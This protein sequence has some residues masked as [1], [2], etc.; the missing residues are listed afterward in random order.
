MS[1]TVRQLLTPASLHARMNASYRM[2]T[3]GTIPLG[4]LLGGLLVERLGAAA[5]LW[6]V[7]FLF[8]AAVLPLAHRSVRALGRT[9]ITRSERYW[10]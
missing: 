5:T 7:P 9:P 6:I 2:V 4:A 10:R 1:V 8:T 3:F